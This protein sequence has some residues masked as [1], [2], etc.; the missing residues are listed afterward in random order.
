LQTY[1]TGDQKL[2]VIAV[3]G[4]LLQG[5]DRRFIDKAI[6]VDQALV[7]LSGPGGDLVAGIE[8]GKAIRLKGFPTIVIKSFP[9]AS[10]CAWAW[11]GGRVRF[12]DDGALIGFHAAFRQDDPNR[13]PDSVGNALVGA[14][15]DRLGLSQTAIAYITAPQP[16]DIHWLT[17]AEAQQVGID[18]QPF[19]L[20]PQTPAE[21]APSQRPEADQPSLAAPSLP[22][23]DW[24]SYGEWI[25][26][27][28]RENQFEATQLA[29]GIR[30]R[31]A[32]TFVFASNSGWFV[33]AL[34]PYPS[35][36]ASPARD[37]LVSSGVI[38]SDSMVRS[39]THFRSLVWG[40]H[41]AAARNDLA[42]TEPPVASSHDAID[43]PGG[44][45]ADPVARVRDATREFFRKSSMPSAQMMAYLD[46]VYPPTV[47]YFGKLV[48]KAD[49]MADKATFVDRWPER[50]YTIDPSG[51]SASCSADGRCV[52]SGTV[53]LKAHS[54]ER[55]MTSVLSAQFSLTFDT[56]S[57]MA[58]VS[59][60]SQVVK[61]SIHKQ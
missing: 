12:M 51:F 20:P 6:G 19:S 55:G 48:P 22:A 56:T 15:L 11:L 5:D 45:K 9:C 57:G 44:V 40:D 4:E 10:A 16:N 35:G 60:S 54:G 61:R 53:D 1:G 42:K 33:V 24:A 27:A 50:L 8:I 52:T 29:A 59:E 13:I 36:K 47:T 28:S 25:Q 18:V 43:T 2:T 46:R 49:V 7:L 21:A 30:Q 58:L 41:P 17:L 34:G 23:D 14:Y 32:S 39:G 3:S 37:Q 31:V 26:A 38:P